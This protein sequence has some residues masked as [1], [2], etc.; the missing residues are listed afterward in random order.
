MMRIVSA[1]DSNGYFSR[2]AENRRI[3]TSVNKK[4]HL[5]ADF[6]LCMHRRGNFHFAGKTVFLK[7][8]KNKPYGLV[9]LLFQNCFYLLC[10][11][12]ELFVAVERYIRRPAV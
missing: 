5:A 6:G 11:I 12:G 7:L 1:F 10:V 9:F 4:P 2:K 8:Q 3:P